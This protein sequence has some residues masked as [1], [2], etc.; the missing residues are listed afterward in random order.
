MSPDLDELV[1]V[2][3]SACATDVYPADVRRI[4][5]AVLPLV[6]KGPREALGEI[7]AKLM[8]RKYAPTFALQAG[9]TARS[10]LA[11]IDALIPPA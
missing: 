7:E 6:L 8:D 3:W 10:A 5:T 11:S 4:L 1:A 9:H 2:G